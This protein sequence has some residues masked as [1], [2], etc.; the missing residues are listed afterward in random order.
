MVPLGVCIL[1]AV[2]HGIGPDWRRHCAWAALTLLGV[3]V[4]VITA[5][6]SCDPYGPGLTV[7]PPGVIVSVCLG[8]LGYELHRRKPREPSTDALLATLAAPTP[9]ARA[10]RPEDVLGP[11]QFYVDAAGSTVIVD[12]Q[13]RGRYRQQ[14]V[15]NRGERINC[16]G[17]TWTVEG[18]N[19]EL[20]SYR[21]AVRAT[22]DRVCWFFGDWQDDLVLFAK[23][24]P[25]STTMLLGLRPAAGSMD[26]GI[27]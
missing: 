5:A 26:S 1:G 16:P 17:G 21:S 14:I 27:I 9:S 10:L 20:T 11:W 23:D 19:L 8:W 4:L 25:E 7:L 12:L 24:E 3:L 18:P 22:L 13:A 15:G 2:L 6:A